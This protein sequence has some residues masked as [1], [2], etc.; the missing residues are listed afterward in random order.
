MAFNGRAVRLG[1]TTNFNAGGVGAFPRAIASVDDKLLVVLAG[2]Y[3]EI[4]DIPNGSGSAAVS[5]TGASVQ[6]N[7]IGGAFEWNSEL[8]FTLRGGN[9]RLVRC[10]NL[11]TG[12]C[13]SVRDFTNIELGACTTDG[14][15]I[16]AFASN[17]NTLYT[18]RTS[19]PNI[20]LPETVATI[21][22][23]DGVTEGGIQGMFIWDGVHYLVGGHNDMLYRLSD[24]SS[25]PIT[26]TRVDPNVTQFGIGARGPAG[27]C[28]HNGEVYMV[29]GAIDALTR[30][31]NPPVVQ[32]NIPRFAFDEGTEQT[33]DMTQYIDDLDSI[34]FRS[35]YT[36]PAY[37]SIGDDDTS[38]DFAD[39]SDVTQDTDLTLQLSASRGMDAVNVD[40]PIRV[41]NV[42]TM[43]PD[44]TPDFGS[45][46]ITDI[47]ATR[48]T[49]SR[50]SHYLQRQA[51]M[52]L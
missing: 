10:T 9:D 37:A 23:E 29:D 4:T 19:T 15:T 46:T 50:P 32:A 13:T 47:V 17:T 30:L 34:A 18:L 20:Y 22:Y 8:W 38:I 16:W 35:G 40:M 41:Q 3:T 49:Q 5:F 33:L 43:Q 6:S 48:G 24:V 2:A 42:G 51:A 26:A 14:T 11:T 21:Q 28:E 25:T 45:E 12:A 1:T 44:L 39:T 36:E 27:A 52:E 7:Q 31:I